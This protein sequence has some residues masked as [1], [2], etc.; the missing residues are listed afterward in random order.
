M[1]IELKDY[2]VEIKEELTW[3]DAERIQSAI[4]KGAKIK[5]S[6]QGAENS[7]FEFD[8]DAMLEAKYITFERTI[9]KIEKK[10]T[11]EVINFSR[12]FIDNLSVSDGNK[13]YEAVNELTKKG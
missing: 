11:K 1:I 7:S 13:L 9:L 12:D 2:E 3:G 4:Q 5:G 10:E 6:V 8:T